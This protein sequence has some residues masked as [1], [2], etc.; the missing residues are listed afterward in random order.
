MVRLPTIVSCASCPAGLVAGLER[1]DHCPLTDRRR[2]AGSIV[3]LE[4]GRAEV[5]SF[6]KR[7][8]VV[9]TR[10]GTGNGAAA[11]PH[12]VRG[13]GEFLGL[14]GLVRDNYLDT[15]TVT[16][17]AVLCS[18]PREHFDAWLG[19]RGSPLRMA[20]EQVLRAA[21]HDVPRPASVDGSAVARV[22]RWLL[23]EGGERVDGSV[24][25]RIT[26][27]LLGMTPETLSRALATLSARGVIVTTRRE[28]RVRDVG[29]LRALADEP[30]PEAAEVR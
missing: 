16:A 26:A 22:A 15:A 20:F 17:D 29:A 19:G 21:C 13:P 3:H 1:G 2:R 9:L 14:E 27:G 18:A 11:R 30:D 10:G 23:A 4:G 24:P 12:A 7:G 8:T 6:V 5:V 28:L 25:R